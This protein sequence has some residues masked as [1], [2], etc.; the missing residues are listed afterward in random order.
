M[1]ITVFGGGAWGRA[2]CFAL[3]QKNVLKIVSRKDL[4]GFLQTLA[5][6]LNVVQSSFKEALDSDLFVNAITTSALRQWFIAHKLPKNSKMLFAC[7]GIE[8]ESG[9]F[10]SDIACEFLEPQN[11]CFLAGPSFAK[12]VLEGLS[13]ALSIHG[14]NRD[15]AKIFAQCMPDFIKAYVEGDVIGG[16]IAGAYKNVIAIASGICDGLKLGNNARA[17]LLARGLIEMYRFGSH[18]GAHMETF[19]G[20]SGAG[21]LFLSASSKLSRNYRVGIGLAEG[22]SIEEILLELGEV[23]EGVKT[24]EAI[25]KIAQDKGIYIPIAQEV[26]NILHKKSSLEQ[27]LRQLMC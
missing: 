18:F 4:S 15:L 11:L 24:T 17:S 8:V 7:K 21:D 6:S 26:F 14:H 23:A 5:P 1:K 3:A 19:L 25:V 27:S 16:E 10:V 2:L 13:C 9:A 20:L 12:E 22:K